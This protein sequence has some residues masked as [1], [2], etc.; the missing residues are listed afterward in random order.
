MHAEDGADVPPPAIPTQPNLLDAEC[1]LRYYPT[2]G[3]PNAEWD[4][5]LKPSKAGCLRDVFTPDNSARIVPPSA[6]DIVAHS[7]WHFAMMS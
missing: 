2:A 3:A 6:K 5:W 7:G 4:T 1:S